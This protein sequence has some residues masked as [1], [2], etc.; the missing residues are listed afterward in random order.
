MTELVL[1]EEFFGPF[2]KV[3][4]FTAFHIFHSKAGFTVD[5]VYSVALYNVLV[6]ACGHQLPV[7]LSFFL[8][9]VFAFL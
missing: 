6:R 3:T 1:L 8:Q 7:D 4:C 5:L 2:E 9:G